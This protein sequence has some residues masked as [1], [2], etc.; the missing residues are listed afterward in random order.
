MFFFIYLRDLEA[1]FD[2]A[3]SR[4]ELLEE[5][6][7]LTEAKCQTL[8]TKVNVLQT[9]ETNGF[10]CSHC[11]KILFTNSGLTRHVRAKHSD[12]KI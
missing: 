8:E 10:N 2:A 9:D 7:S 5:K 3:E 12:V 6:L 4:C 1:K 11:D